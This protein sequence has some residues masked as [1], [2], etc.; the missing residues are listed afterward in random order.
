MS[1]GENISTYSIALLYYFHGA[2]KWLQLGINYPSVCF[3]L[4]VSAD[5]DDTD[6]ESKIWWKM[7]VLLSTDIITQTC[8]RLDARS[9]YTRVLQDFYFGRPHMT[10]VNRVPSNHEAFNGEAIY[11]PDA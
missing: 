3:L 4:D 9:H 10:G 7:L 8:A 5:E 2:I 6:M 11:A 1:E